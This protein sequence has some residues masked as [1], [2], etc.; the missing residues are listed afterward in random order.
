MCNDPAQQEGLKHMEMKVE[1]TLT[2]INKIFEKFPLDTFYQYIKPLTDFLFVEYFIKTENYIR[3]EHYQEKLMNNLPQL[4]ARHIM[5]F[6][7][8]QFLNSKIKMFQKDNNLT[9]LTLFNEVL[10]HSIDLVS[11]EF[12]H[13]Y[14]Y[15]RFL[16]ICK[17][18]EGDYSGTAKMLNQL[19]N[20]V[21]FKSYTYTDVECKL[22][23]ALQYC[24]MGEE[25]L[26][27]QLIQS[28]K[29][30]VGDEPQYE[31]V[32]LYIKLIKTA[33]KTTEFRRKIKRLTELWEAIQQKNQMLW[34]VQL[35][36]SMLRR[37]ANP[38]K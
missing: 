22:F 14:T 34:Y 18:Y 30:Q 23:Q 6:Y 1:N 25:M 12:Y 37:M 26:C 36:E 29:R 28:I 21:T 31:E 17:F 13:Y 27:N 10:N 38:I 16:A 9:K 15:H 32:N 8:V 35:D 3:A 2:E 19:R 5:A 20:N 33:L 11:E 7:V 4:A 24:I